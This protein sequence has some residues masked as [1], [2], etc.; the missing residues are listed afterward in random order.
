MEWVSIP[1]LLALTNLR[2]DMDSELCCG[3]CFLSLSIFFNFFLFGGVCVCV[4]A[5][6]KENKGKVPYIAILILQCSFMPN[7][8]HQCNTM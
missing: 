7:V 8:H 4:C 2:R 1:C 5:H 3:F 6:T